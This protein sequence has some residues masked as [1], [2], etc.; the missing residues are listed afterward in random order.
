MLRKLLLTLVVL[1]A[2]TWQT[3]AQ[4]GAGTLKG[5]VLDRESGE[6]MPFV[7]LVLESNGQQV[8]GGS[9]NFDGEFTIKPIPAGKY[10]LLVS[11]VGYTTQKNEG[12]VINGNKITFMDVNLS[13]GIDLQEFEVVKY[14]V[15]LIDKDGG[16]SGGTVTADD[17]ARMPARSAAAV[18]TT[19]GGV[20]SAG[21]GGGLSIR[22]SRSDATYYYIDGI[23]VRGS[24]S[25]PKSAIQEVSVI[26]G[27]V[28]ANYGDATGGIISITTKGAS[29]TFFGGGEFVTSGFKVGDKVVGLDNFGYNLAEG[30]LS[31]PIAFRNKGQEDKEAV[32]GFFLSGNFNHREDR[33]PSPFGYAKITDS[34]K[35]DLINNPLQR[36]AGENGTTNNAL[37]L[38]SDDFETVNTSLNTAGYNVSISSKVDFTPTKNLNFTVGGSLD[39]STG[40]EYNFTNSLMNWDNNAKRTDF[41][42]RAFARFTQRFNGGQ[43]GEESSSTIKNAFYSISVDYSK[44]T[45]RRENAVHKDNYFAYGHVGKFQSFQDT[46]FEDSGNGYFVMSDVPRD[47]LVTFQPN[48][49]NREMAATTTQYFNAFDE[50]TG[51]YENMLQV[52][53]GGALRNGDAPAPVYNRAGG[54]MWNNVG[55]PYSNFQILDNSQFR[56]SAQGSADVGDHAFSL[57]FEYEQRVDRGFF[58]NSLAVPAGTSGN[59]NNIWNVMRLLANRHISELDNQLCT[60]PNDPECYDENGNFD[61]YAQRERDSIVSYRRGTAP[62]VLYERNVGDDQSTFDRNVRARLGLGERDVINVDEL[63]PSFFSL[64]DFSADELI[65]QGNALVDYYGYDYAGNKQTGRPAFGDFFTEKNAAGDFTRPVAP[66]EPIYSAGYIMDKFA[67]DDIIFN[68]GVRVD[69]FDA[70]QKVLK[71]P[72][73][74]REARTVGEVGDIEGN[75]INHPSNMG[76]DF[77]VYV[78]DIANPSGVLGYRDGDKFYNAQ[79]ALVNNPK[80]IRTTSG[81]VAP[82]LVDLDKDELAPGAFKDYTPQVNVM[83]RVS[84]SFPISDEALFFAHY[85]VLTQRPSQSNRLQLINYLHIR[86]INNT[87]TNPLNNPDLRP[88]RTV[89][90]EL[91]FQQVLSKSSSL[92]LSA[93]YRDL[94]DMIQVTQRVGAYPRDYYTLDNLDFGTVKGLTVAYDLRRTSNVWMRVNY[95]LQFAEGTGSAVGGVVNLQNTQLPSLRTIN[96][97]NYDR[98]HNINATIDYRFGTGNEYHG[99]RI[100]DFEV[101]GNTGANF[102]V[103]VGS[104]TPYSASN[105]PGRSQLKGS[106]NGSRLPWAYSTNLQIDRDFTLNFGKDKKKSMNLNAY[107]WIVNLFDTRNI[108][109]AYRATGNPDDDGYLTDARYQNQIAN[110]IDEQSYRDLYSIANLNPGRY[111]GPRTIRLGVKFDF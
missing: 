3:Q 28:P 42:W 89:D 18:A 53:D 36:N 21:T 107:V 100:G 96:P 32:L 12:I 34:R 76:D 111:S 71:D 73:L 7:N 29:S 54:T 6:P 108:T 17:I 103:N 15:P 69:R 1:I 13:S 51:N 78:N 70:N 109:G 5:K 57:G 83:P 33:S 58:L 88:E 38:R 19:V 72:Y 79:G 35:E 30:F 86:N 47:T 23:K 9:T 20:S 55:T 75:S 4:S 46:V 60:D 61:I 62:Y 80:S 95:T 93:F 40:N 43:E 97:F 2:A 105:D 94:Q 64:E 68:V 27:G 82:Y 67:F 90:Y 102:V 8:G 99:P 98:R 24:N 66:F 14:V 39:Y 101:F 63:D 74:F 84:F 92:K 87:A 104:G 22:G 25:L 44:E 81:E 10:S 49:V 91:G 16:A 37:L 65:N 50:T 110:Q 77:V 45:F 56:V 11:F 26:T 52:Q 41:D 31:G 85:D 59:V 106:I 48:T